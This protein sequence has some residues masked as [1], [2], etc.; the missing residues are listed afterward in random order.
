MVHT[1]IF[2]EEK[3]EALKK[4]CQEQGLRVTQQRI[5]IF[6]TVAKSCEHPDAETVYAAVKKEMP[7][8]S[9]DTVYRTLASLEELG[10]IFRVDNMLPKARFDADI[11]PHHHFICTNCNEVY[12]I[13]V[14]PEEELKIPKNAYNIGE[15]KDSNL[16]I[17][18]VCN[19][20]KQKI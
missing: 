8:I 12:D 10:M 2:V 18:G 5:S 16:Q 3:I 9:F 1:D 14:G 15:I 13:V 7:N 4:T 20:C 17:R 6:K 19:K 11:R